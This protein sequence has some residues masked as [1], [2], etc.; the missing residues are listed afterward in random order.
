MKIDCYELKLL[1]A[2][3]ATDNINAKNRAL[4]VIQDLYKN[5]NVVL[6][7]N[8]TQELPKCEVWRK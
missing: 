1:I 6:V 2:I 5:E 3:H 7:V 8:P 4:E